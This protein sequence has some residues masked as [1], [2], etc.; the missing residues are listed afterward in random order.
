[1]ADDGSEVTGPHNNDNPNNPPQQP[2]NVVKMLQQTFIDLTQAINAMREE[3][4]LQR[5]MHNN[6]DN[7]KPPQP[8]QPPNPPPIRNIRNSTLNYYPEIDQLCRHLYLD[9]PENM[10]A[11][12]ALEW[13]KS[14]YTFASILRCGWIL[15]DP[16][17]RPADVTDGEEYQINTPIMANFLRKIS[18]ELKVA[19]PIN[20]D[21]AVMTPSRA[22]NTLI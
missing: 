20:V 14:L 16:P 5:T 18:A 6:D 9:N 19:L 13:L 3:L 10:E 1:M 21:D 12:L 11:K 2:V 15:E 17:T 4:I 8:L 22:Y 7:P